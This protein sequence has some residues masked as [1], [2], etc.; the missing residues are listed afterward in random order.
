MSAFKKIFD[1]II[2]RKGRSS[3]LIFSAEFLKV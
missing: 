1:S 3:E 2:G